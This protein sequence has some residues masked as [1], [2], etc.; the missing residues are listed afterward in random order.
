MKLIYL[1]SLLLIILLFFSTSNFPIITCIKLT[2]NQPQ[3]TSNKI[4]DEK[5]MQLHLF[6]INQAISQLSNELSIYFNKTIT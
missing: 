2:Y 6:I 1:F 5:Q 4:N 3:L